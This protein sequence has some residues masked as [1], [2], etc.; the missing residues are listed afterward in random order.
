MAAKNSRIARRETLDRCAASQN[1]RHWRSGQ[2]QRLR[3]QVEVVPGDL[4]VNYI[5]R[6]AQRVELHGNGSGRMFRVYGDILVAKAQ[7]VQVSKDLIP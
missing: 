2:P 7:A 5:G 6:L 1:R 4:L 3:Q